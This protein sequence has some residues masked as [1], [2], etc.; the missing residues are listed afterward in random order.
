M[1]ENL[2]I[3]VSAR[4]DSG[5]SSMRRLRRTDQVPGVIYGTN[6]VSQSIAV[7]SRVLTHAFQNESF[8]SQIVDLSVDGESQQVVV[9]EVQRH[10]ATD[11][12]IHVDFLR[13]DEDQEI[14]MSI[15]LRFI[16]ESQCVGVRL[17]GGT[18]SHNLV[19]VEVSC[20]P[21][22]LPESIE[23]DLEEVD[24]GES[25]HL[26]DLALPDG[27]QFTAYSEEDSPD[28]NLQVASVALQRVEVEEEEEEIEGEGEE[29]EITEATDEVQEGTPASDESTDEE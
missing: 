3:S 29:G 10:P 20:L 12:I 26:S 19:E 13:I 23:V 9:R 4:E 7:E 28:R 24:L 14:T 2:T 21:R 25:I 5:T 16:N 17:G 6:K 15:P 1:P 18:I 11:R 27:V 22:N 8:L